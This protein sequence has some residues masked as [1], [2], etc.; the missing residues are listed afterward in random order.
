M[1]KVWPFF[2]LVWLCL[3]VLSV[4]E[5]E[6]VRERESVCVCGGGCSQGAVEQIAQLYAY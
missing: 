2:V 1:Q 4:S 3:R 6:C 5:S